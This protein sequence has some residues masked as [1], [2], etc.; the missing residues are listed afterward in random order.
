LPTVYPWVQ[1]FIWAFKP[2]D[3]VDIRRFPRAEAIANAAEI[4]R[5]K[6]EPPPLADERD[7]AATDRSGSPEPASHSRSAAEGERP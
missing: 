4:A 5:L 6:G 2:T 7:F 3:K 1:A